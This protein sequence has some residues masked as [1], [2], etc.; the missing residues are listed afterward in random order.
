MRT[1]KIWGNTD[2]SEF[3]TFFKVFVDF[4]ELDGTGAHDCR[5]IDGT[6]VL[7]GA[8]TYMSRFISAEDSIRETSAY[9]DIKG[10]SYKVPSTSMIRY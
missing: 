10:Q 2:Q 1:F 3:E 7:S 9:L 8:Y 5:H 4:L 6:E